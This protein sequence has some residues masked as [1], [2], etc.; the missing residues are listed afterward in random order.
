MNPENIE[1]F[2]KTGFILQGEQGPVYR[3]PHKGDN[4]TEVQYFLTY[5]DYN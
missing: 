1:T 4:L 5:H 2:N 3:L